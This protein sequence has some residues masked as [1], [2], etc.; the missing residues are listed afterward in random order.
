ME[1]KYSLAIGTDVVCRVLQVEPAAMLK[2]AGIVDHQRPGHEMRVTAAQFFR[3][4]DAAVALYGQPD[5][6][7]RLCNRMANGPIIPVFFALTCAPDL[8]IGSRRL[9]QF[10]TLLGPTSMQAVW[11]SNMLRISYRSADQRIEIPSDL[12]ALHLMFSV[13]M[14]RNAT[15][16]PVIPL[17][18][19]L[20]ATEAQ[21]RTVG[22]HLGIVPDYSTETSLC[23]ASEDARRP[24]ISENPALWQK[25]ERD[26]ELQMRAQKAD[27]SFTDRVKAALVE[28]IA[29][30]RANAEDV[31]IALN[32]SRSTLQRRLRAEGSTFQDILDKMR[33][34]LAIR[35]L[36]DS[37]LSS[38]EIG[39]LLGYRD[40]N[41][42]ARSFRRWKGTSPGEYRTDMSLG[43]R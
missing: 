36:T 34:E 3:A 19:S 7:R 8:A 38:Q 35:Y 22:E 28:L 42:F 41:S 33:E 5:Y 29:M 20:S 15:G 31:G 4:W 6:L 39:V 24:F 18:A 23:Y 1:E 13:Q 43:K 2:R 16:E 30:G 27:L 25:F 26:F 14:V 32:M 40:A 11:A 21:R 37:E 9:A 10:K 17:S 12:A